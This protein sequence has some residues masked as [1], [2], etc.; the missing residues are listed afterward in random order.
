[1]MQAVLMLIYFASGTKM[2]HRGISGSVAAEGR[3]CSQSWSLYWHGSTAHFSAHLRLLL[4][5]TEVWKVEPLP[6]LFHQRDCPFPCTD[7]QSSDC[8]ICVWYSAGESAL[9]ITD[10][11]FF[12]CITCMS[13]GKKSCFHTKKYIVFRH[14][15]T[16]S[17]QTKA[18][19]C[20]L[21][22]GTFLFAFSFQLTT[23]TL[24][25]AHLLPS[26]SHFSCQSAQTANWI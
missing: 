2:S 17:C 20:H 4:Q 26:L 14:S 5:T 1:M 3:L 15:V 25:N 7:W 18:L 11:V 6:L 12:I 23:C 13:L 19:Q 10:S 16:R 8:T 24:C 21:W 22:L 9:T